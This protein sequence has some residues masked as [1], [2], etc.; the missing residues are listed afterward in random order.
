MYQLQRIHAL[1]ELDVFVRE[2][3]LVFSLTQLLLDQLL[4]ARSKGGEARTVGNDTVMLA[5]HAVGRYAE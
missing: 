3:G 4:C 5:S 2:L 1:L